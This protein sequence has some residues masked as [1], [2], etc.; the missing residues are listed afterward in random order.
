MKAT[1]VTLKKPW[2]VEEPTNLGWIWSRT[3]S[4]HPSTQAQL[5]PSLN[6]VLH[7]LRREKYTERICGTSGQHASTVQSQHCLHTATPA[8]DSVNFR[9]SGKNHF[10]F[11]SVILHVKN[12]EQI[13]N[14]CK[15]L[16]EIYE[17]HKPLGKPRCRWK[18]AIQLWSKQSMRMWTG[19]IWLRSGNNCWLQWNVM[20]CQM[21]SEAN[22]FLTHSLPAI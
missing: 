20:S 4:S 10:P 21:H 14:A 17:W 13:R 6:K 22:L 9:V 8:T 16:K 5:L 15:N 7:Q 1:N 2:G 11:I 3:P 18:K 19:L 12:M